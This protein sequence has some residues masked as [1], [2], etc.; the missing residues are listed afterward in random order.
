MNGR[1]RASAI[2][3]P[4]MAPTI[5]PPISPGPDVAATAVKIAEAGVRLAHRLAHQDVEAFDVRAGG[6]LRHHAAEGPMLLPLRAHD[7]G[8]DAAR[9]VRLA[10]HDGRGRLVAAR[11]QPEHEAR[12]AARLLCDLPW[13]VLAIPRLRSWAGAGINGAASRPVPRPVA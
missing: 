10:Q 6:D 5:S 11:L 8:Q 2:A 4:V 13:V 7:V 1:P 3:L 12:L 9:A